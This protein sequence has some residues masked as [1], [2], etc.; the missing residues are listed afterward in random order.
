[1]PEEVKRRRNNE[2]LALQNPISEEDNQ[3]LLGQVEVLVEG[4]SKSSRKQARQKREAE[5]A[6]HELSAGGQ[7]LHN[8]DSEPAEEAASPAGPL[9]LTGRTRATGSSCSTATHGRSASFC[10]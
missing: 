10:R 5:N 2:L 1:M 3:P 4:P 6:A 7:H 8:E 9:Q